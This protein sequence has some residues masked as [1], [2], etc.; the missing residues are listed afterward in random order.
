MFYDNPNCAFQIT[1]AFH[2]ERDGV[3]PI[4][5]K[6]RKYTALAYRVRGESQLEVGEETQIAAA[7]SVTYIPA[8]T[9]YKRTSTPEELIVIHMQGF[10]QIGNTIECIANVP[11]VE[12]L[13]RK[14]LSVWEHADTNAYNRA[15]QVLYEI[16]EALQN[17][18][19]KKPSEIPPVIRPGV[20]R[21]R[22]HYNDSTLH[23]ADLASSCFISEVYFRKLFLQYFGC[24]PRQML[25]K[26]RFKYACE[27]LES[28]YY[29]QKE[30][31]Q[32]A[33][34]SDVKYFRTAFKKYFGVTPGEYIRHN[35]T[36]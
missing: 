9:D 26:M 10:G 16:F 4:S 22:V 3:G 25:A 14:L 13:F 6:R 34:F 29:T 15:I 35:S 8:G 1:G 33:G 24:S 23:I 19:D 18:Q 21:L 36:L 7:G 31:A 17:L 30:A 12:P 20:E 11:A 28:G 27:L 2:V 32:K 5:V